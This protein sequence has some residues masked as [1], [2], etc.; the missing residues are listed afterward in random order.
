[1]SDVPV[2]V[3]NPRVGII[4][5]NEWW[6][7]RLVDEECVLRLGKGGR[8][9]QSNDSKKLIKSVVIPIERLYT[10]RE[11]KHYVVGKLK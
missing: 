11:I 3:L 9:Y 7:C 4:R 8:W 1:M 10:E 6:L 5:E 2:V